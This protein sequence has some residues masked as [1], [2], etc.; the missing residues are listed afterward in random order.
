M[1]KIS[2]EQAKALH[3]PLNSLSDDE[4]FDVVV[5]GSGGAGLSAALFAALSGARVLVVESTEYVG[6]TTALSAGTSW[7]PMSPVGLVHNPNDSLKNAQA[8]LDAA[9]GDLSPQAL[10]HAFL[11]CGW[12]AVAHLQKHSAVRYQARAHH[13][14]YMSDLPGAVSAGRAIEPL[15]FDGRLLGDLLTLVRPPIAEFT[16][17]GGMMVDRDDIAHLLGMGQSFASFHH[18][19]R[20]L[21]RHAIDCVLRPRSTRLVMGNALIGRLLYSLANLAAPQAALVTHARLAQLRRNSK[22]EITEVVIESSLADQEAQPLRHV[23][24]VKGGVIFASGGWGR[25]DKRRVQLAGSA[26]LAS[27]QY[28]PAAPGHTGHA[29]ELALAAGARLGL[30]PAHAANATKA[31]NADVSHAFWAPVSVRQ[32]ADGSLASF[33]HFVMDRGKPGTLCVN[34]L[35]ERFVNEAISYHRFALALQREH[36]RIK[37]LHPQT[38]PAQACAWLLA[39]APALHRYGLGM[40]RPGARSGAGALKPFLADGY[41]VQANSLADLSKLLGLPVENLVASVERFN[42]HAIQGIDPEFG[43][44]QTEYERANGDAARFAVKAVAHPNLGALMQAPFFAV[45]LFAGDIGTATGLVTNERGQ[46]LDAQDAPLP[47]LYACGNDMHSIMGGVY[48]APGIT[49]GP[50]LAFAYLAARHAV[51]RSQGQMSAEH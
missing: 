16:V 14:D 41:L 9:V 37:A 24:T 43:R 35:G 11:Q 30:R 20:I 6:G 36:L 4:V 46:L 15:P 13:P 12:Q 51:A 38:A 5:V 31:T 39:D 49:L 17:L 26:E 50:G 29:L 21:G 23:V 7:I 28:S 1:K 42:A 48:P 8:F 33:P 45:R 47:G 32:R 34:A 10:R 40:V 27:A 18:A 44:G 2:S 19:L 22:G 3:T 25:S